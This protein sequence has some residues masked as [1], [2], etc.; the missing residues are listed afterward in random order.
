VGWD[1]L[2]WFTLFSE[3]KRAFVPLSLHVRRTIPTLASKNFCGFPQEISGFQSFACGNATETSAEI[4]AE[5][6]TG[7]GAES[8]SATFLQ[9]PGTQGSGERG[10]LFL[11]LDRHHKRYSKRLPYLPTSPVTSKVNDTGERSG[12]RYR[13]RREGQGPD[14]PAGT[15]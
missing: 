1:R 14:S 6:A 2:G 9:S 8:P 13:E 12:W 15:L 3:E 4:A 7:D 11:P 10:G 5:I